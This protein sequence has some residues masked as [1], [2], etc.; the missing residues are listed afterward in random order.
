MGNPEIDWALHRRLEGGLAYDANGWSGYGIKTGGALPWRLALTAYYD[1]VKDFITR[2][3]ARGQTVTGVFDYA[4]IRRNVD[5]ELAGI[6]ADLRANLS[7]RLATR[8]NVHYQ[9]GHNTTDGRV[10]YGIYPNQLRTGFVS[11]R[12]T[13]AGT[14]TYVAANMANRA[15]PVHLVNVMTQGLLYVVS[16]DDKVKSFEDLSGKTVAMFFKG[17]MPDLICQYIAEQKG[18]RIGED[19]KL[20]YLA[21]PVEAIQL[22]LSGRV[23]QAVLPEPVATGAIMKGMRAARKLLRA[24]DVQQAWAGVTGGPPTIPQAGMMIAEPLMER[25]PGLVADLQQAFA[26]SADWVNSNPASAGKLG[27]A[28]M[29]LKPPVIE[30]SIPFSNIEPKTGKAARPA[31]ED[32]YG[33]LAELN[34]GI[35]GGRLPDAGFYL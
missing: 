9:Y 12:W 23:D 7:R 13:L 27:A 24:I 30:R 1:D 17:D 4:R 33:R 29:P 14:P 5:A 10:L 16:R 2:D 6:A 18:L 11:G 15:V 32:F 35:I 20:H 25:H 3:R 28:Y 22:L 21:T 8:L 31:L 19:I 34:P 26:A